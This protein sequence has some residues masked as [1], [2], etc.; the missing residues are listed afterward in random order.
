ME[1][2]ETLC[3]R[4]EDAKGQGW[5]KGDS[6]DG[7]NPGVRKKKKKKAKSSGGGDKPPASSA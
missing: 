7:D 6:S 1:A 3:S 5:W 4:E 2:G